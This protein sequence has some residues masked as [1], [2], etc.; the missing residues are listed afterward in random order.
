VL[1]AV[2]VIQVALVIEHRR[3]RGSRAH[4]LASIQHP[5]QL[6][7]HF[8]ADPRSCTPAEDEIRQ[9]APG[10]VDVRGGFRVGSGDHEHAVAQFDSPGARVALGY[11]SL[12]VNDPAGLRAVADGG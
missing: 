10:D 3:L 4:Q 1:Q 5:I 9:L 7:Q 2:A 11:R 8:A 12:T 6:G